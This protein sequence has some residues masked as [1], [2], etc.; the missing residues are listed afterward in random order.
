MCIIIATLTKLLLV[1]E[2][3]FHLST[4]RFLHRTPR[5]KSHHLAE[6]ESFLFQHFILPSEGPDIFFKLLAFSS[7]TRLK[8]EYAT[9]IWLQ[10]DASLRLTAW[11][12]REEKMNM[13]AN[14]LLG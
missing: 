1:L 3:I 9:S 2:D 12:R 5:G 6:F 10:F 7:V 8:F 4:Q 13:N 14:H 11:L